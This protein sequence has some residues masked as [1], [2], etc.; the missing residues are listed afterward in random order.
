MKI[1]NSI[2]LIGLSIL[3]SC[4]KDGTN[5]KDGI[6][7]KNSIVDIIPETAGENCLDGGL[8]I[9]TGLD[10][11]ENNILDIIE[12][13]NT[14]F[15]CNGENT[16]NG[17]NSLIDLI[18]EPVGENCTNGG[19]KVVSGL[20][21]NENNILDTG[22]IQNEEYLCNGLAGDDGLNSL[23]EILPEMDGENCPNGGY[24]FNTG[25]DLNSDNILEENEIQSSVYVCNGL[26]GESDIQIR[27]SLLTILGANTYGNGGASSGFFIGILEK[28]N[29][30]YWPGVDS[31]VFVTNLL[32]AN[33]VSLA[34]A[35][36]YNSSDHS[37]IINST[38]STYNTSSTKLISENIFN[39]LPDKEIDLTIQLRSENSQYQAML[40]GKSYLLLYRTEQ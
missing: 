33:N 7:G 38:V 34:S 31:I 25:T 29:K 11:N 27:L 9:I 22:E 26:N 13:Q 37:V 8:K 32:T 15:I 12:I 40:T 20:D 39:D 6:S 36:L 30:N 16:N 14:E 23:V 35:D 2:F 4:S 3:L 5:G 21:V 1:R 18:P 17:Y 28:F 19:Y 10:V 24:V